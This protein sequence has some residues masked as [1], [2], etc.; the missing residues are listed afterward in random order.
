MGISLGFT[1]FI[2]ICFSFLRPYNQAIYAPKL[3]HA[4]EK[5]APPPL[6]KKPWSWIPPLM[7]TH[8][9]ALIQQIGMDATMFL[10]FIRMCRNMFLVLALIGVSILVPVNVTHS[11]KE[12]GGVATKWIMQITPRDVFGAPQWAQVVVAWLFNFVIMGFLWWN[13]R[14]VMFLRRQYFETD[15]YQ[16]SLHARTL[17]VSLQEQVDRLRATTR[18]LMHCF[19]FTIFRSRAARMRALPESSTKSCPIRPLP[20]LLSRAMSRIFPTSSRSM[21]VPSASWKRSWPST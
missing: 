6:G 17:M 10:R 7:H 14:K 4:D 3:K 21:V 15:E 2:A 8:E 11:K 5:H 20:G 18:W 19:S 9:S 16:N 12:Y 1:A 13:Y